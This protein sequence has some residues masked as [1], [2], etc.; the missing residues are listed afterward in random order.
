MWKRLGDNMPIVTVYDIEYNVKKNQII[1]GTFGRSIQSFDLKQIGI[2]GL[3][4]TNNLNSADF[5]TFVNSIITPDNQILTVI[6][7]MDQDL[8]YYITSTNGSETNRGTL[9]PGENDINVETLKPGIYFFNI[10]SKTGKQ[11]SKAKKFIVI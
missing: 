10:I 9:D 2:S 8:N 6:L 3:V 4:K 11:V 7:N 1:A 5:V